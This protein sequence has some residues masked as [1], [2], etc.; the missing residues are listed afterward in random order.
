[1]YP[2][3][4]SCHQSHWRRLQSLAWGS[5]G[6]QL[7][8]RCFSQLNSWKTTPPSEQTLLNMQHVALTCFDVD[9][10]R[11]LLQEEWVGCRLKHLSCC[12]ATV[13]LSEQAASINTW[14]MRIVI[15]HALATRSGEHQLYADY[16]HICTLT[17]STWLC[18]QLYF[19]LS[20]VCLL[21]GV[22]TTHGLGGQ[23]RHASPKEAGDEITLS[24]RFFQPFQ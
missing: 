17:L 9:S 6:Q 16:D 14:I 19:V 4:C 15:T 22:T 20:G 10:G 18:R 12:A 23:L 3:A 24:W 1:M 13:L 5:C 21:I 7:L 2:C 8:G 11:C